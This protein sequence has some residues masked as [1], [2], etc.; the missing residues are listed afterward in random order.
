LTPDRYVAFDSCPPDPEAESR[1]LAE[2][3]AAHGPIGVCVLGL[4]TNGHLAM[5]EPAR[6]LRPF[7]H[8]A[9]LAESSVQHPMMRHSS[10][11]PGYGLTLGL[12]EILASRRIL[13]LVSGR[14]KR[15][16]LARLLEPEITPE[17]PASFLWLHPDVTILADR[18]A[19][20]KGEP[21]GPA[22]PE[23]SVQPFSTSP[24]AN[25]SHEQLS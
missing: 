2:W 23:L 6:A 14:H 25:L 21:K 12:A 13:L 16:Q 22:S 4:G 9:R 7:A 20:G 15:S 5:N 24:L 1:R 19:A 10:Q 8:V 18:D 11:R 17:F 3:V